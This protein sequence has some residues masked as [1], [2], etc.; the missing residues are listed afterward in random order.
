MQKAELVVVH[1]TLFYIKQFFEAA[2]LSNGHFK[3]YEKLEVLPS[4]IYKDKHEHEEAIRHL[5][6][7]ILE[8]F[9]EEPE[10][11]VPRLRRNE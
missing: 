11:F 6:K 9:G 5:Y 2:G 1:L 10:L 4:H 3:S 7:G 8:V